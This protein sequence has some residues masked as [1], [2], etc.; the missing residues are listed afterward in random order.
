ME[1]KTHWRVFHP[2][3]HLGSH[4][5]EDGERK[6]ATIKF[7]GRKMVKDSKGRE[8]NCLVLQWKDKDLKPM[9]LNVTNSKAVAKVAGS[10]FVED[11]AG[12]TVELY[13]T[14]VNAFGEDMEAVRIMQT[15]PKV[16]KPELTP[17][18]KRWPEALAKME[19]GETDVQSMRK[20][21]KV[22]AANA[23]ILNDAAA[24]AGVVV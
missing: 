13:T 4:D 1:S 21:W 12:V 10:D 15:A 24:A 5:F 14:M 6:I 19:R 23:K 20:H 2:T 16:S 17:D 3:D 7:G 11:W 8:E 18:H 22:S 9:I